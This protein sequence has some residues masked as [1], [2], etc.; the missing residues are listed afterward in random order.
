MSGLYYT[1]VLDRT[2]SINN[3]FDKTGTFLF[4]P[5]KDPGLI[6]V[7]KNLIQHQWCGTSSVAARKSADLR[8]VQILGHPRC[9]GYILILLDRPSRKGNEILDQMC[10]L[11]I[12]NMR[13]ECITSI[14][15]GV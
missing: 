1:K 7:T 4:S 9:S 8:M 6:S 2:L 15:P 12:E 10:D 14:T 3:L 5:S 13:V 11:K